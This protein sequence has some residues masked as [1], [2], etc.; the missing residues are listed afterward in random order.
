MEACASSEGAWQHLT[1]VPAL[2]PVPLEALAAS[3]LG[4]LFPGT[5]FEFCFISGGGA[6]VDGRCEG[7]GNE[8]DQY[9]N[10][11][12]QINFVNKSALLQIWTMITVVFFSKALP[13]S[14]VFFWKV[15]MV[16]TVVSGQLSSFSWHLACWWVSV[17]LWITD[18]YGAPR[19]NA[20]TVSQAWD[21]D[22][23]STPSHSVQSTR[24]FY[25]RY[26]V[27][28]YLGRGSWVSQSAPTSSTSI[29]ILN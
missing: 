20:Y 24:T 11:T 4:P 10:H 1:A 17:F 6:V 14:K 27:A 2:K 29:H 15:K 13:G 8:W 18:T 21:F 16:L 7:M 28:V 12:E 19:R 5:C 3:D 9:E 25:I 23:F 22:R 26:R